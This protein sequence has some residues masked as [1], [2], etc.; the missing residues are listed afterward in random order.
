MAWL[1]NT[2]DVF[3]GLKEL[4]TDLFNEPNLTKER[5]DQIK[6]K[7]NKCFEILKK[8]REDSQNS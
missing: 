4:N 6:E 7:I 5:R 2:R 8:R 3:N 1:R